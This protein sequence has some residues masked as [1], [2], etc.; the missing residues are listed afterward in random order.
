MAIG[1]IPEP[2]TGIPESII[3]AKGDLIVGTA[4]DTPGILSVGTN[5]YTLVADSAETTGIKWAAPAAS[6]FVGCKAYLSGNQSITNNTAT[7]LTYGS[8]S[9]D[10]DAFHSTSTNTSRFTIPSGKGG[11]YSFDAQVQFNQVAGAEAG[12]RSA[13]FFKN[14]TQVTA[15]VLMNT[16]TDEST[17]FTLSYVADL[18][19]T[20]YVELFVFQ[21]QGGS[22]NCSG[23]ETN[24]YC[25]VTYLGA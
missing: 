7:A 24:N 15:G 4:N 17:A 6:G 1:R 14:G 21:T 25:A 23:G 11:K 20:D 10:T 16:S 18:V 8:E 19:A 13:A 12:L 2:G 9:F 3:A 5:G 22:V